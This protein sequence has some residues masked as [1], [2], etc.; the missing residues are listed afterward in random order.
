MENGGGGTGEQVRRDAERLASTV[1]DRIE[2]MRGYA[3]D[4]GEWLREFAR[5]KPVVAI[6]VAAGIGF[7]VG[8][9][10]SKA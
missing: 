7:L 6:A 10:L 2:G 1:Q 4:A 3:E 9:L 8:R 5:E